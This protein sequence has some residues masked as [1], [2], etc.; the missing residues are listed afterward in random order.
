MGAGRSDANL[1][2][3]TGVPVEAI[4][5]VKLRN[6][7]SERCADWDSFCDKIMQNDIMAKLLDTRKKTAE[8]SLELLKQFQ[9]KLEKGEINIK[10]VGDYKIIRDLIEDTMK[11][12]KLE[13]LERIKEIEE[14]TNVSATLPEGFTPVEEVTE[15]SEK[16]KIKEKF[17]GRLGIDG[18]TTQG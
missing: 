11:I 16:D 7:W 18:G 12:E 13:I 10:S 9:I 14:I 15:K 3:L 1:S 5:K 2:K 8:I 6:N 4:T 17:K